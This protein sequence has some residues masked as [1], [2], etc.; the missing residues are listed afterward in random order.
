[1]STAKVEDA[2]ER[3]SEEEHEEEEEEDKWP[4]T[5]QNWMK[6]P[7]VSIYQH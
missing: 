3:S 6:W 5:K 4:R 1:L 7:I 2:P